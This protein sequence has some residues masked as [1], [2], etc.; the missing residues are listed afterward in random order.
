MFTYYPM[1]SSTYASPARYDAAIA[2]YYRIVVSTDRGRVE[3]SCNAPEDLVD[4]FRA[5]LGGSGE[6]A[7][8]VWREVRGCSGNLGDA[9][10]VTLE[11]DVRVFNWDRLTF[12]SKRAA[13]VLGPLAR[14][15]G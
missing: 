2:P 13:V 10:D 12:T 8:R 14:S 7:V 3:L 9:H 5:A 11:G 4:D 6:A 1:Y 15:S